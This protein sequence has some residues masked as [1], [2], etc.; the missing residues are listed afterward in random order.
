[1]TNTPDP[2]PRSAIPGILWPAIPTPEAATALALQYQL[3]R[4]QWWSL[5]EIRR[6]QFQQLLPLLRHT[7][8]TIPYYRRRLDPAV[9]NEI[10]LP[11]AWSALPILTRKQLQQAGSSV[12]SEVIPPEHGNTKHVKTSGS[13]GLP[14]EVLKTAR[15]RQFWQAFTLREHLWHRR[16]L[17]GTLA[18]IRHFPDQVASPPDGAFGQG[19]G[20][21][22][23][24][25][26]TTG[27]A[28]GLRVYTDIKVQA[29]WLMRV[30]PDYLITFPSNLEA[31][32][33]FFEAANLRLEKLREVRTLSET[34]SP[35][36]RD[37]CRQAWGVP[38]T[39]I[40][41]TQEVGYIALQCPEYEH[42]HI[43][44]EGALVEILDAQNQPCQ[45]GQIGRVI[46][47][48]LHN[49]ATPL[50]RYEVGDYAEVGEPCP[51][52]RGLPVLKR[53]MGRVR[54]MLTLP[55]GQQMW[56]SVGITY[57]TKVSPI[58]QAQIVQHSLELVEIRFVAERALLPEEDTAVRE[59]LLSRLRHPFSIRLTQVPEI[60][61]SASGK[62]EEF[63]SLMSQAETSGSST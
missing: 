24:I 9:L 5:E 3:D 54:N 13:T 6:Y 41:S 48:P 61:R 32:I 12:N 18:A 59:I 25:I 22:T 17:S 34:V 60:P 28:A 40:Y 36:V 8:E 37:L 63:M 52:G 20:P 10:A 21:A 46:V 50:L 42:Y 26:F 33:R 7:Y 31:L 29:A 39:D 56:P 49:F 57:F 2:L 47:T 15:A 16:D 30:Q 55:D 43:Q 53:I 14:V 58:S 45:P 1:M 4:S 38:L 35:Q 51:C 19:W 62:F 23:D 11:Q 27:M 44:S